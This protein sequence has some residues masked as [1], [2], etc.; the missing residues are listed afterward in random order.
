MLNKFYQLGGQIWP[1]VTR[2]SV[3]LDTYLGPYKK[4]ATKHFEEGDEREVG[5]LYEQDG[6]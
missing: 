2:A 3:F 5:M 6:H 1:G 4:R